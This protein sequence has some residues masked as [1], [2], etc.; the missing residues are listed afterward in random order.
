MLLHITT[1][2]IFCYHFTNIKSLVL[3]MASY[4]KLFVVN[5]LHFNPS[6]SSPKYDFSFLITSIEGLGIA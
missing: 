5:H 3:N 6:I 2:L 4:N 1:L